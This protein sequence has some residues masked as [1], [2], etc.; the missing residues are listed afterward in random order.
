[1]NRADE[2][3]RDKKKGG[4]KYQKKKEEATL[5]TTHANNRFVCRLFYFMFSAVRS[6]W[7]ISFI[8]LNSLFFLFLFGRVFFSS[9]DWNVTEKKEEGISWTTHKH[10]EKHEQERDK[11]ARDSNDKRSESDRDDCPIVK[12]DRNWTRSALG[13]ADDA[14]RRS[15]VR[16]FFFFFLYHYRYIKPTNH[17]RPSPHPPPL[18][19]AAATVVSLLEYTSTVNY[20]TG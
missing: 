4:Y 8:Y 2:R 11:W 5:W 15:F 6:V 1:M 20:R 16:S 12:L 18:S 7:G 10:R 3:T 9:F 13:I 14:V 17:H 19:P